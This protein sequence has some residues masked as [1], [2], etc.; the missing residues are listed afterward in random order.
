MPK[1]IH[2]VCLDAPA[3]PDYGGAIDMYYKIEALANIGYDIHLHYFDYRPLRSVGNLQGICKTVHAYK[4]KKGWF[5]LPVTTPFIISSR[6]NH[7]LIE[8][9][10]K[11]EHPVLLEGL[12]CAGIIPY[13]NNRKR[14]V[15]RMHNN[16]AAYY[17]YLAAAEKHLLKK[18]YYKRESRLL[19]KFQLQLNADVKLACLSATDLQQLQ[20]TYGFRQ[21]SFVPCFVPWQRVNITEGRGNY[22]LYHGNM[23]V[24]EN[25]EAALWLAENIFRFISVPLIIA[26]KGLSERLQKAVQD[27]QHIRLVAD[28]SMAQIQELVAGAQ[29]NVLPSLNRTGVKLKL[30]NALLNGRF[31]ITNAAG[32][33]GSDLDAN[34]VVAASGAEWQD[35]V[36]RLM[37]ADFTSQMIAERSRVLAVYDNKKNAEKLSE[38]W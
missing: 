19:H 22:C 21:Q 4:R 3:P 13:V 36:K 5:A 1:P 37:E 24:S 23:S 25:E 8:R 35:A 11:D 33:E 16:E 32:V 26:G 9:L 6:I 20:T 2:I 15:V 30:L 10:N 17:R 14:V 28:P 29:V 31:C 27:L 18:L 34:V 38:L 7:Q 12:H